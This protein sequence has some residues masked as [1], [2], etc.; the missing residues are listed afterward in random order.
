MKHLQ[1]IVLALAAVAL[2][3]PSA[4]AADTQP[5]TRGAQRCASVGPKSA[6]PGVPIAAA[7]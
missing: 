6:T 5:A 2:L 4:R 7:R 1:A 3:A